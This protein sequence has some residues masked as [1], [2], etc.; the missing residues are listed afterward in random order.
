M[1]KVCIKEHECGLLF[2]NGRY[3]RCLPPGSHR[4]WRPWRDRIEKI[5][6]LEPCFR[7]PKLDVLLRDEALRD[8][9][10]LVDLRSSQR[11]LVWHRGR[12]AFVAGP[13]RHAFWAEPEGLIVEVHDVSEVQLVHPRLEEVVRQ[14]AASCLFSVVNVAQ[15]ERLAVLRDEIEIELLGPGAH[16]FWQGAAEVRWRIIKADSIPLPERC[17]RVDRDEGLIAAKVDQI[18]ALEA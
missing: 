18:P 16:V 9:L 14:A 3:A 10:E 7:H 17:E 8:Q 4:I 13:G 6:R 1:L 2:I 15:H 12:L 5:N 11:A